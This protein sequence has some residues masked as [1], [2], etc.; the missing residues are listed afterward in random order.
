MKTFQIIES[1]F[2]APVD[3]QTLNN[4][5][6]N[7]QQR[8][9]DTI[10]ATSEL[11]TAV[12]NLDLNE[13]EEGFRRQLVSNIEKTIDSNTQFGN[14]ASAYDDVMKLSGDIAS[15]P[16]LI[17]K[18][19]AQQEYQK[20]MTDLEARTD[21]PENYKEYYRK[22]N[23]YKEGVY[24]ANGNW[25][26]G[27]KWEPTKR[28]ALN[29]DKTV[30]MDA[31]LKYVTPNKGN[32]SVTTWMDAN[33][34]LTKKYV[35]G[36]KMV[37]YNTQTY[38]YEQLTEQEIKDAL[39]S[40]IR[41][42]PQYM[43]SLRQDYDI[44]VDDFED[45]RDSAFNVNN[46]TG[47][48]ISFETFVD[49]IFS[50]MIKSKAYSYTTLSKEDFNDKAYKELEAM[51]FGYNNQY[52]SMV[53]AFTK[54]GGT[55]AFKDN[56]HIMTMRAV[57]HGNDEIKRTVKG[58]DIEGVTDKFITSID[59]SNPEAF[60]QSLF[61]LD[62][63][64]EDAKTLKRAYDL[65]R[66]LY[67]E[68]IHNDGKFR[69]LYGA[70]KYY[71]GEKTI[72]N[73]EHG[74]FPDESTMDKYEKRYY[75]QWNNLNEVF[76]PKGTQSIVVSTPNIKTYNEFIK[77][78]R[79]T[80]L[81]SDDPSKSSII[82]GKDKKGNFTLSLDRSK[83]NKIIEFANIY[84]ETIGQ[85]RKGKRVF[86]FF[87]PDSIKR[88]D[89][90]GKA[91]DIYNTAS[92]ISGGGAGNPNVP[93]PLSPES[94]FKYV[95]NFRDRMRSYG[96]EVGMGEEKLTPNISF[97][98]GTP[99][100]VMADTYLNLGLFE[101]ST[102]QNAKI[103]TRD[104]SMKT[105]FREVQ[106]AG[107]RNVKVYLQDKDGVDRPVVDSKDIN[108]LERQLLNAKDTD[109]NSLGVIELNTGLGRYVRKIKFIGD[110]NKPITMSVDDDHNNYLY[111]LNKDP[112]LTS[113]KKFYQ[114]QVTGND[115][116]LGDDATGNIYAMPDGNGN[117]I[118]ANEFDESNPYN[119]INPSNKE[120]KQTYSYLLN[121]P[122]YYDYIINDL[123]TGNEE[124]LNKHIGE[125]AFY[126]SNVIYPNDT[127]EWRKQNV[128]NIITAMIDNLGIATE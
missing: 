126:L 16:Q 93:K 30:I 103:K 79:K 9:D 116:L 13:A 20:F 113:I 110:D 120:Q 60:T 74:N 62:I 72:A 78:A 99:E 128:T 107:L 2:V 106:T 96:N 57:N 33:G 26:K 80:G 111:D 73:I 84:Q 6:S 39:T 29:I 102:D 55:A 100:G 89:E 36:A 37:R 40:V 48:P 108:D 4:A 11:K 45:G 53:D 58:F 68:D 10:K 105:L 18:L 12:A 19:K 115:I 82:V 86:T 121:V 88:I 87:N 122:K 94:A 63:T 71:A 52:V 125:Y 5:Y 7:L 59:L 97:N 8:H 27:T 91:H 25:I 95:T 14:L 75:D 98:A 127:D 61:E 44:A 3:L 81:Y 76:F 118:I 101:D 112:D 123:Q 46:G 119:I 114:S 47:K 92:V 70:T 1:P 23:P 65:Q 21:L 54:P 32:Y 69:E 83:N 17:S 35:E 104:E 24:D 22:M 42:N 117:F 49:N 64:E 28:A 90:N 15:N 50:P 77:S 67:A 34:N 56:S 31:A 41:A 124:L 109:A 66:A 85:S 51:G 38:Q 43:D